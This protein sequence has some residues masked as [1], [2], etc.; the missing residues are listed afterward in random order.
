M[1]Y[2]GMQLTNSDRIFTLAHLIPA[3]VVAICITAMA[4]RLLLLMIRSSSQHMTGS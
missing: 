2:K 1:T 3:I 4:D